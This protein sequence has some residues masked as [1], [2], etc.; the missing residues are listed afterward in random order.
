MPSS[1]PMC[2][3]MCAAAFLLSI[4]SLD[5]SQDCAVGDEGLRV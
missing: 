1:V 2:V 5:L 4:L 3:V